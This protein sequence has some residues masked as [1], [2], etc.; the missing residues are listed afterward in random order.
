MYVPLKELIVQLRIC[1]YLTIICK[2]PLKWEQSTVGEYMYELIL[3][4]EKGLG[5][6]QKNYEN[7]LISL[8][9]GW[10]GEKL[11]QRD[12]VAKIMSCRHG[13]LL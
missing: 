2:M 3:L 4:I 8:G 13:F 7:Q 1:K 10:I 11:F 6:A 12:S 5:K 9:V